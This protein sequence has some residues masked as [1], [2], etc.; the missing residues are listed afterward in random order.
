[1]YRTGLYSDDNTFLIYC[2]G[3]IRI[4]GRKK[5]S[6]KHAIISNIDPEALKE[7][8]LKMQLKN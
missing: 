3:L 4:T 8:I 6:E 1:M 2:A 7:P 5:K